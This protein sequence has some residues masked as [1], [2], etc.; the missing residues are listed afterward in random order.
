MCNY[1]DVEKSPNTNAVGSITDAYQPQQY[2]RGSKSHILKAKN[3][4]LI[5]SSVD[6]SKLSTNM[7]KEMY[8]LAPW[9]AMNYAIWKYNSSTVGQKYP[10]NMQYQTSSVGYAHL[11]PTLVTGAPSVESSWNPL[12]QNN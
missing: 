1:Y 7:K 2:I 12:I 4:Y 11:Y 9:K 5:D 10:C 8:G 6:Y 3:D